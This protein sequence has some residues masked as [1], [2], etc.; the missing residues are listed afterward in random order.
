M[1]IVAIVAVIAAVVFGFA[2]A[3]KKT[4]AVRAFL[5]E[6]A[7]RKENVGLTRRNY[8]Y[9]RWR[10]RYSRA[11]GSI[12][13]DHADLSARNCQ[14]ESRRQFLEE[15]NAAYRL[16]LLRKSAEIAQLSRALD[17]TSKRELGLDENFQSHATDAKNYII[18]G[19]AGGGKME[20]LNDKQ[21]IRK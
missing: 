1:N 6:K 2:Y 21:V 10:E 5:N 19:A 17:A 11:F 3:D 9:K 12:V 18:G 20:G 15:E 4:A 14:L 16:M 7:T 8:F 13:R